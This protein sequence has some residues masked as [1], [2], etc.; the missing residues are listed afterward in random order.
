MNRLSKSKRMLISVVI[1]T[2]SIGWISASLWGSLDQMSAA[3]SSLELGGFL[4]SVLPAMASI[5]ITSYLYCLV[6]AR[7]VP[8]PPPFLHVVRPFMISQ[9]VCHL[10][11]KIWGVFYQANAMTEWVEAGDTVQ[12]NAEHYIL[13]NYNSVVIALSVFGHFQWG[14]TVALGI[15]VSALFLLLLVLRNS[16]LSRMIAVIMR[17]VAGRKVRFNPC[18]G[19][20]NNLLI[21]G[22]L[23]ADWFFYLLMFA[24]ILPANFSLQDTIVIGACYA[25]AGFIGAMTIILPSGVFV[26]E[27]SFLWIVGSLGFDPIEMFIFSIV[28]R[29][30]FTLV[31]VA[32]ATLALSLIR[33]HSGVQR[34]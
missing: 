29:T 8:D 26:R 15:Y 11:G 18:R 24:I 27:A 33:G 31:D 22:L 5:F 2:A 3:I 21:I 17:T 6:L 28:A 34:A 14:T 10:P 7:Y 23:Q 32:C 20:D 1:I 16:L 9:V 30:L 13:Q 19:K 25:I 4:L 12:A